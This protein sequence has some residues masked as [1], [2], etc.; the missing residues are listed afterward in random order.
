MP[1]REIDLWRIGCLIPTLRR[2]KPEPNVPAFIGAQSLDR[3][4]VSAATFG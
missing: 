1:V 4:Y 2:P 3:L